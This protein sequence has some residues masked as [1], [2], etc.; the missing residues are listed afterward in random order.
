[1]YY[2]L[3]TNGSEI[4]SDNLIWR[5]TLLDI[6]K[7]LLWAEISD[8]I[9]SYRLLIYMYMYSIM[10]MILKTFFFL[11]KSHIQS[12]SFKHYLNLTENSHKWKKS[13][14]NKTKSY[15]S[16]AKTSAKQ[17]SPKTGKLYKS[18]YIVRPKLYQP[19]FSLKITVSVATF[20]HLNH[21]KQT[22][23][24]V[25]S[26]KEWLYAWEWLWSDTTGFEKDNFAGNNNISKYW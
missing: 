25:K 13:L 14:K 24:P 21:I 12:N 1:M 4:K 19:F 20:I 16:L 9:Y 8:L 22:M 5:Y 11:Y 10:A 23:R 2:I 18:N 3:Y 7:L 26:L 6:A 17:L 15:R